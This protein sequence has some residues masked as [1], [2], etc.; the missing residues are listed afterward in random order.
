MLIKNEW[1][2]AIWKLFLS[3]S[4]DELLSES[5]RSARQI[6]TELRNFVNARLGDMENVSCSFDALSHLNIQHLQICSNTN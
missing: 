1:R 4:F 5:W 2:D 6:D 3:N